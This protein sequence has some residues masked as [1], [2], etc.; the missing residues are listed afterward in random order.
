MG[1]VQ[2][3]AAGLIVDRRPPR[4]LVYCK[5]ASCDYRPGAVCPR[6]GSQP[7]Q[8]DSMVALI[9]VKTEVEVTPELRLVAIGILVDAQLATG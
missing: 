3:R 4:V 1:V 7:T 2:N 5:V 8:Q 9:L 6:G